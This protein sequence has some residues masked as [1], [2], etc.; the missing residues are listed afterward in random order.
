MKSN[1]R[2]FLLA[3]AAAL[4]FVACGTSETSDDNCGSGG[5]TTPTTGSVGATTAG[6]GGSTGACFEVLEG[7]WNLSST[8]GPSMCSGFGPFDCEVSQSGC[9]VTMDCASIGAA[10]VT[11]DAA[12]KTTSTMVPVGDG[13]VGDCYAVFDEQFDTSVGDVF[14]ATLICTA[15]GVTCEFGESKVFE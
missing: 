12:G 10:T 6:S 3:C 11:I 8:G 4:V 1:Q 14:S 9:S 7:Q 15:Q 2:S 5:T 13:V